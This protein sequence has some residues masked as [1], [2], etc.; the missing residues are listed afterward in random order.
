MPFLTDPIPLADPFLDRRTRLLPCQRE[1]TLAL[2]MS[3]GLSYRA[4]AEIMGV[5]H[6]QVYF[7]VNPDKL[8][9]HKLM[10]AQRQADGRYYD[11]A[12]HTAAMR[13]HRRHKQSLLAAPLV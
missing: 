4:I 13:E 6:R 2:R 9:H 11:R 3:D 7:V 8:A 5:S 12:R 1:R 10:A